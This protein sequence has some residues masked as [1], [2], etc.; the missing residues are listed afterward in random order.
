[1]AVNSKVKAVTAQRF[2]TA[3]LT[4]GYDLMNPGGLPEACFYVRIVNHSNVDVEVSYDGVH[5][6][7]IV[8]ADTR[9]DLVLQANSQPSGGLALMA[10]G[11][12]VYLFGAA[13][14][15]GYV[16]LIGYYQE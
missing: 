4:G 2:D 14:G 5:T 3:G 15:V 12:S 10:K 6:H 16:Y 11:Q 1:M 13:P 8:H 7:D 9:L